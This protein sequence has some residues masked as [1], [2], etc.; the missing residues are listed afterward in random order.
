MLHAPC[1]AT[2]NCR[3]ELSKIANVEIFYT[4][5]SENIKLAPNKKIGKLAHKETERPCL[6]KLILWYFPERIVE[7]RQWGL[8]LG[9][10]SVTLKEKSKKILDVRIAIEKDT[11]IT[12]K[13]EIQWECFARVWPCTWH[14]RVP[15]VCDHLS[16]RRRVPQALCTYAQTTTYLSYTSFAVWFTHQFKSSYIH[17]LMYVILTI[18][19]ITILPDQKLYIYV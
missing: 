12:G 19:I 17:Q 2:G 9:R 11:L 14:H 16:H 10:F 13:V 6:T 3:C 1:N 5:L 18:L 7:V 15:L 4:I 8:I